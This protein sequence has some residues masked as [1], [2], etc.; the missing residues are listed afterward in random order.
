MNIEHLNWIANNCRMQIMPHNAQEGFEPKRVEQT[1]FDVQHSNLNWKCNFVH[2]LIS[3]VIF[4]SLLS[5][6]LGNRKHDQAQTYAKGSGKDCFQASN[7]KQCNLLSLF[8]FYIIDE[9]I[10]I[11]HRNCEP[12]NFPSTAFYDEIHANDG[13]LVE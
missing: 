9:S 5:K 8:F 6:C 7:N 2:H 11:S 3:V 1:F 12:W 4:C 13:K 10:K